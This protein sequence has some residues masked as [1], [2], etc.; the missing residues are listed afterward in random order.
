MSMVLILFL[1]CVV[2]CCGMFRS[3]SLNDK[4]SLCC[5]K[6]I[7]FMAVFIL[8]LALIPLLVMGQATNIEVYKSVH[9]DL[10]PSTQLLLNDIKALT[11]TTDLAVYNQSESLMIDRIQSD[12]NQYQLQTEYYHGVIFRVLGAVLWIALFPIIC[13]V[14]GSF[15]MKPGICRLSECCLVFL[16]LIIGISSCVLLASLFPCQNGCEWIDERD[17]RKESFILV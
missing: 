16:Y 15:A 9:D 5:G 3:Q 11:N 1:I 10:I 12:F 6:S 14:I 13:L 4:V 7:L 8:S 2:K 17:N